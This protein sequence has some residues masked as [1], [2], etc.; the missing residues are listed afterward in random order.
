VLGSAS[1]GSFASTVMAGTV[2]GLVMQGSSW[3][4]KIGDEP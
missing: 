3:L 2:I 1:L 4:E